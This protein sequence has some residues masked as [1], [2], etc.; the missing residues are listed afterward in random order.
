[1]L[2]IKTKQRC[3]WMAI[4]PAIMVGWCAVG[5]ADPVLTRSPED[6]LF[7]EPRPAPS[8]P[9]DRAHADPADRGRAA[10]FAPARISPQSVWA[11][12]LGLAGVSEDVLPLLSVAQQMRDVENMLGRAQCGAATQHAQRQIL[13]SLDRLLEQVGSRCCPTR[14]AAKT[15]DAGQNQ[16]PSSGVK[17]CD[18]QKSGPSQGA[19]P[20][21]TGKTGSGT[22]QE[23][24]GD[25]RRVDAAQTRDLM[26]RLWGEL[27]PR[28]RDQVLQLPAEEFLPQYEIMIEQYFRRLSEEKRKYSEP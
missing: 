14:S 8:S 18:G 26:K 11:D 15:S 24:S 4:L 2:K 3:V 6:A 17:P 5:L 1:M 27:P 22:G 20:D 9:V 16:K 19:A 7:D 28:Q 21:R 23:P 12:E 10:G 13:D 25:Q